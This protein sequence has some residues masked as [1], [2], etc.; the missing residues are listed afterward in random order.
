MTTTQNSQMK[1]STGTGG[2]WGSPSNSGGDGS[3]SSGG[4]GNSSD[5]DGGTPGK[6][7]KKKSSPQTILKMLE[8]LTKAMAATA[9]AMGNMGPASKSNK[10]IARQSHAK[11]LPIYAGGPEE[12]PVFIAAYERTTKT[13]SYNNDENLPQLHKCLRGEAGKLLQALMVSPKNLQK[14]LDTVN[15]RIRQKRHII[16]AMVEKAK[17]ISAVKQDDLD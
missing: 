17:E 12:W 1:G 8:A 14:I 5:G 10:F 9:T 13:C 11:E 7:P 4:G 6:Y 16:E 3:P 15:L 2:Q